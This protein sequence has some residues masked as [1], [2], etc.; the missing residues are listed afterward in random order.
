MWTKISGVVR[1]SNRWRPKE[2]ECGLATAP[3][4]VERGISVES[5]GSAKSSDAFDDSFFG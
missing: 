2:A 4:R 3:R 5:A 1:I